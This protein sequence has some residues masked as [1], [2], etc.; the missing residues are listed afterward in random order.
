MSK[1][2]CIYFDNNSTTPVCDVA[3]KEC[4]T[5]LDCYNPS[6]DSKYTK[7]V[8]KILEDASDMILG[9]CGVNSASHTVV[10]TSG[11]TESNCFALRTCVKSYKR[12]L[13]QVGSILK[14]HIIFGATE[15]HSIISCVQDLFNAGEIE[16]TEIKPTI[17]GNILAADVEIAIKEETCLIS[18]MY[19]NNEIPVITDVKKIGLIAEKHGKPFHTDAT[20]VFG[21]FQFNLNDKHIHML[22]ASAHKF[23]GPKGV[24]ILIINNHLIDPEGYGITAEINGSQQNKLRGG[25]ENIAYICAMVSALQHTFKNRKKK[26]VELYTLRKK[27]I[28]ELTNN[29]EIGDFAVYTENDTKKEKKDL[30]IIFLGPPEDKKEFILPNTILLSICKNKGKPFCNVALKHYLDEKGI[31]VSIG[32][33]C[34]TGNDKASHVLTAIG[35]PNVVKVGVVRISFGDKNTVKEIHD[36]I[37]VFT[38]GVK[39]QCA[40]IIKKN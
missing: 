9:H 35:A 23:Y 11:A 7:S 24:G 26:N 2:E 19:A 30:E 15:H 36:F 27:C 4:I 13:Q 40:D 39:K 3:K 18:V 20:Q 28:E 34:L 29:Y 17:Y 25:T 14:P 8:K 1:K 33:A 37:K 32:S 21:K 10:F 5:W 12:K 6:N 22:S 38:D 31:M 16:Y